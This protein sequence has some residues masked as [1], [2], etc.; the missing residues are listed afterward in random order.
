MRFE[1]YNS[2]QFLMLDRAYLE[3]FGDDEGAFDGVFISRVP[4]ELRDRIVRWVF[5][6]PRQRLQYV[7][8]DIESRRPI[9]TREG[10]EMFVGWIRDVL[11]EKLAVDER[12]SPSRWLDNESSVETLYLLDGGT[13]VK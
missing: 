13:H 2:L 12:V 7:V 8:Y 5:I 9:V 6:D 1:K 10:W 3:I 11:D 4:W